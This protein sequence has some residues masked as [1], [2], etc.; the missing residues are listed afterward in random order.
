M[1][2]SRAGAWL[3]LALLSDCQLFTGPDPR[4]V[5][6]ISIDRPALTITESLL[7]TVTVINR[8]DKEALASSPLS[9][10][11]TPAF[12]VRTAGGL[13]LGVPPIFCA[14]NPAE[15]VHILFRDSIV[16]RHQ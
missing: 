11:C 4:L 7:V 10:D 15:P 12:R 13:D 6:T 16:L 1:R 3:A 2:V 9:Y 14:L 5:A 8:G